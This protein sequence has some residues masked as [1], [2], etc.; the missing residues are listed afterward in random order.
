MPL[1]SFIIG[2]K[3]DPARGTRGKPLIGKN[4]CREGSRGTEPAYPSLETQDLEGR[5]T[6]DSA[7]A[8]I[9]RERKVQGKGSRSNLWG[10]ESTRGI[11]E[12]KDL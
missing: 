7:D 1:V 9:G 5:D 8:H 6:K 4:G 3:C 11:C 12:M 10:G 2:D